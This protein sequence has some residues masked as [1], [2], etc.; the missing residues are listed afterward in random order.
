MQIWEQI[1]SMVIS[2][3]IFATLFVGLFF[4]QLKDS[5]RR[6]EKYQKTIDDLTVHLDIIEDVKEDVEELKTII[7]TNQKPAKRKKSTAPKVEEKEPAS[8]NEE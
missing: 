7:T 8:S 1:I 5:R 2:N 6:E 4:Y 3:G